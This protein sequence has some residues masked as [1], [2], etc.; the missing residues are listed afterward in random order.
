M[1]MPGKSTL[2]LR[3]PTSLRCIFF[4]NVFTFFLD[5]FFSDTPLFIL[6][7]VNTAL[8]KPLTEPSTLGGHT[9]NAAAHFMTYPKL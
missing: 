1:L 8:T 6:G 3:I 7:S 5:K 2:T 9:L 4:P